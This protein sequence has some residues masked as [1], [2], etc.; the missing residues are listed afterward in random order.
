[1]IYIFVTFILCEYIQIGRTETF[2]FESQPK[3]CS[4]YVLK[5]LVILSLNV[6]VKK[7]SFIK[8]NECSEP[9]YNF[10]T[11][12]LPTWLYTQLVYTYRVYEKKETRQLSPD[13]DFLK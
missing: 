2:L 4:W 7:D 3:K 12:N 1:M 5:I 8:K 10:Q 13:I 11:N 9:E 6:L